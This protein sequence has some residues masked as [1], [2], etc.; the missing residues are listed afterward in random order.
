MGKHESVFILKRYAPSPSPKNISFWRTAVRTYYELSSVD[1]KYTDRTIKALDIA[2]NLAPTDPKLYYNK[3]LI[4]ETQGKKDEE[5]QNL[6]QALILKPNYLE[7]KTTLDEAT[8][9]AKP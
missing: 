4:L 7:A 8:A 9:S 6:M 1:K 3:A 2:I 5:I